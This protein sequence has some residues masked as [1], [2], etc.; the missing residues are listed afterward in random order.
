MII[1]ILPHV[2]LTFIIVIIVI[3]ILFSLS[4]SSLDHGYQPGRAFVLSD[5]VPP[6]TSS[7]N[8]RLY[9]ITVHVHNFMYM[10]ITTCTC[11]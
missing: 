6:V 11:T 7:P 5:D 2:R 1:L 4:L 3:I 9:G 8:D 10:Y